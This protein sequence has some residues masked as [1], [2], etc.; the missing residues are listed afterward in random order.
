[1][2][3]A[4]QKS[5]GEIVTE[6]L[7]SKSNAPF[8]CPECGDE[9]ILK[10]GATKVNYFTHKN[11]LVGRYDSNESAAHPQ[12]KY[13]IY[14]KLLR[15]PNVEKPAMKRPLGANRPA[16]LTLPGPQRDIP[17]TWDRL[18]D[19]LTQMNK[20]GLLPTLKKDTDRDDEDD[21]MADT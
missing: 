19:K 6:Y 7:A 10:A 1:M 21:S 9:V 14:Q 16:I 8:F 20:Q 11:P 4:K 17:R 13:E 12:C 5:T 18:L 2:L 15:Q 3:C